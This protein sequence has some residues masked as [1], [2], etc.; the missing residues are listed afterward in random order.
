[1]GEETFKTCCAALWWIDIKRW[2]GKEIHIGETN[3]ERKMGAINKINNNRRY[4]TEYYDKSKGL[5][6]DHA[7]NY[8]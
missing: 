2:L 4:V 1:M 6:N 3:R 5:V 8:N 7:K